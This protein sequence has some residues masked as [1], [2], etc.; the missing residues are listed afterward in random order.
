MRIAILDIISGVI[1]S[2]LGV[3][4]TELLNDARVDLGIVGPIFS[5]RLTSGEFSGELLIYGRLL[6][7]FAANTNPNTFYSR[8]QA[9]VLGGREPRVAHL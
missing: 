9:E 3:V 2:S 6:C 8:A 7:G 5:E 4:H 1:W